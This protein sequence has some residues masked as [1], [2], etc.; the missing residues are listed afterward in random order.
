MFLGDPSSLLNLAWL[1][2]FEAARSS[3]FSKNLLNFSERFHDFRNVA[4]QRRSERSSRLSRMWWCAFQVLLSCS[5]S[6]RMKVFPGGTTCA[7]CPSFP[8]RD[9]S[10]FLLHAFLPNHCLSRACNSV[11][12][13]WGRRISRATESSSNPKNSRQVVGPSSLFTA[14]GTGSYVAKR[15]RIK[16][17][18]ALARELIK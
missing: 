16:F 9:S 15:K 8:T 2:L 17:N 12:F 1:L 10:S 13:R 18:F 3:N 4:H 11:S 5:N 7:A 14:T 6:R